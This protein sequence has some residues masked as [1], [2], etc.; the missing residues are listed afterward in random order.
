[1]K[2][3]LM[4]LCTVVEINMGETHETGIGN[5]YEGSIGCVMGYDIEQDR[6]VL[7]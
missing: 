3:N 4:K 6:S 2:A 7:C 5:K 1:M